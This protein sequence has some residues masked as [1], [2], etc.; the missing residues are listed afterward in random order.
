MDQKLEFLRYGS[1][2]CLIIAVILLILAIVFFFRYRIKDVIYELS[3][4]AKTDLTSKMSTEYQNT[5]SLRSSDPRTSGSLAR[6][7][8]INQS[9]IMTDRL[10]GKSKAQNKA[11]S[12]KPNE[13]M[14]IKNAGTGQ[15]RKVSKKAEAAGVGNS[16][17]FRIIKDVMVIHTTETV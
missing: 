9:L 8:E 17:G 11:A 6:S 15:L 13:T 16:S 10:S 12:G 3:G 14:A 5:G 1:Y 7:E 2:A 4:K